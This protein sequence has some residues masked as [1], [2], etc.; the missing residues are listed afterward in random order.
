MTPRSLVLATVLALSL[1]APSLLAQSA[2]TEL[3]VT[4]GQSTEAV[5]TVASQLRIFGE[6]GAGWQYYVEGAWAQVWGPASDAF[7]AAYPYDKRIHPIELYVEKTIRT[8]PYI[9][10]VRA[11]RYRTPFGIYSRSDHAYNGFLRAPLIRYGNYWALSNNFLEGGASVMAGAP[12]L[13][14][15]AS[16]GLPQDQ[17]VQG[18]R[19]GLDSVVRVQG[20]VGPFI[21]AASHIHTQPSVARTFA[22]GST[23][24]SGIDVRWM[25]GGV[26]LRGEWIDGQPFGDARTFGG[27]V[28]AIV[29][30]PVMGPVTAVVRAERLDYVARS[31]S[32]PRRYTAG[33]RIRLSSALVGQINFVR[34]P[35]DVRLPA[36]SALDFALTVTTRH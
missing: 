18:R 26:Q 9:A 6:A 17:D 12:R 29:H 11:G 30:R 4:V 34:Q 7:G 5:R 15:E 16:L 27:Y 13:F 14:V 33:A 24:F 10:G 2:T 22:A 25:A 31:S 35:T 3:D 23:V 21:I 19:N 28:D 20:S 1:E 8:G 36:K 32:F